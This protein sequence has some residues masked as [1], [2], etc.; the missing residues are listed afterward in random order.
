MVLIYVRLAIS[1]IKPCDKQASKYQI[2]E[3]KA[4]VRGKS[5]ILQLKKFNLRIKPPK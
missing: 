4:D 5:A 1:G 2:K 3:L